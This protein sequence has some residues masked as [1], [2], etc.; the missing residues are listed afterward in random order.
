MFEIDVKSIKDYLEEYG[1]KQKVV[2]DKTGLGECKF[3]LILQG[4]RRLE[5]GEYANICRVVGV[6]MDKFLKPRG[7]GK[8]PMKE[9][10]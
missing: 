1:I 7:L 6:P 4:K 9:V 10:V 5:A 2:A 3:S 8:D